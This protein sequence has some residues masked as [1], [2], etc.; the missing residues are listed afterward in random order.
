[1]LRKIRCSDARIGMY[2]D[3]VEG[4]WLDHALWKTR[5]AIRSADEL[6]KLKDAGVEHVWIDTDKGD[7]VPAPAAPAADDASAV[8]AAPPSPAAAV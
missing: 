5:F 3:R 8:S 7:D 2:V 1:M 4:S 6:R